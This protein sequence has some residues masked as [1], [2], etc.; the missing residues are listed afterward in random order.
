MMTNE[1]LGVIRERSSCKAFADREVPREMLEVVAQAAIEA[2]S[3]T[4][5]QPWQ[6][7]VVT[8][9]ALLG[10][11]EQETLRQMKD[12]PA[13]RGFY[14]MVTAT[15]MKLLMGAPVMIVVA[16]NNRDAYAGYDCGIVCENMALAAQSL[17]L[18]SRIVGIPSVA[19]SGGQGDGLK[20]RLHFPEGY[21]FGLAVLLG[22]PAETKAPHVPN[23]EKITWI[24]A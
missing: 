1:T 4:N 7:I 13:F 19:F 20:A 22:E 6:I 8:D 11:I 16:V 21:D 5:A 2:P 12:I 9:R 3:A 15:G 17:G 24:T 10:E 23:P 14:D 18:G